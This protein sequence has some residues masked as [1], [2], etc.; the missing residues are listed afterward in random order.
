MCFSKQLIQIV[1]F[2][3]KISIAKW[4]TSMVEMEHK[5]YLVYGISLLLENILCILVTRQTNMG[6]SSLLDLPMFNKT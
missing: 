6:K 3:A 1:F 4:A 2:I 5:H